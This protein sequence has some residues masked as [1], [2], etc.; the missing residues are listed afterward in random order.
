MAAIDLPG[1]MAA[2]KEH[3]PEHHFHVH[4][5][6]HFIEMYSM[7]QNLEVDVHPESACGE[8][9]DLHLALEVDPRV[10]LDFEEHVDKLELDEEPEGSFTLPLFFRWNLPAL[11]DPPDLLILATDLAGVGGPDLPIE[12]SGT[13]STSLVMDGPERKLT[14]VAKVDVKLSDLFSHVQPLCDV[15]DRCHAVSEFLLESAN[16]WGWK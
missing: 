15:L 9:L 11:K 1:F 13:D 12:V 3:A 5:E 10:V 7:R 2:I 4:D 8:P 6:R 14:I 16:E